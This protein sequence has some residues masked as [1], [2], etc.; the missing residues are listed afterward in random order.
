MHQSEELIRVIK[1]IRAT[2]LDIHKQKS[3][4][5][6][7]PRRPN[8]LAA[9]KRR[10]PFLLFVHA[11]AR[12]WNAICILFTIARPII[13]SSGCHHLRTIRVRATPPSLSLSYLHVV[14]SAEKNYFISDRTLPSRHRGQFVEIP[15][16]NRNSRKFVAKRK[17]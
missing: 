3:G 2:A 7:T 11:C 5:T 14:S 16:H 4:P 13:E 15:S 8:K 12:D 10:L 6:R 9:Q 17:A 1:P